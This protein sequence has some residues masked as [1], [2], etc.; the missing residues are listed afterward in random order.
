MGTFVYTYRTDDAG[1]PEE[2]EAAAADEAAAV[3]QAQTVALS[4]EGQA[5]MEAARAEEEAK[6]ADLS[7]LSPRIYL[8]Q[9]YTEVLHGTEFT[10]LDYVGEIEDD[11]DERDL[12]YTRIQIHGTETLNMD[13]PGSYTLTFFVM[14]SEGH[15][16]NMANLTVRVL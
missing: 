11:V 1:T 13:V 16:S 8:T 12:L 10:P 14:D 7:P 9:Y 3:E 6:M 5:L 4:A 15:Q 2:A